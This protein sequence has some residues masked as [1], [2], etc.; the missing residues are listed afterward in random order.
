MAIEPDHLAAQPNHQDR[1]LALGAV[2]APLAIARFRALVRAVPGPAMNQLLGA[3][4]QLLLLQATSIAI[5][6]VLSR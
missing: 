2:T 6:V 5:A 4:A 3:T 1:V